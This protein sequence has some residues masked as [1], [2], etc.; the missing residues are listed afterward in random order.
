MNYKLTILAALCCLLL[1]PARLKGQSASESRTLEKSFAVK[2][3][4]SLEVTNKYGKVH[5]SHTS[6]DSVNITIEMNATASN[7]QKLRKL[8]DGV[9][10]ELNATNYFIIAETKFLKG[11][12]NLFES[13]RSITNNL[14]SSESRLEINYYIEVP[15]NIDVKVD[16]RYGDVYIE[17]LACDLNIKMNNGNLKA[18]ELSGNNFFDLNFFDATINSVVKSR[19]KLSYGEIKIVE[20]ADLNITSSSSKIQIDKSDILRV[21]SKRDKYFIEEIAE[22]EGESYFTEYSIENLN[23]SADITT[24]YGSMKVLSLKPGFDLFSLDSDYTSIDLTTTEGSSFNIDIKSINCPV[25]LPSSWKIEEKVISEERKEYLY[26]GSSGDN[27]SLSQMKINS[28]RGKL[29]ISQK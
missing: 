19:F 12:A 6:A 28:I 21:N 4:M 5:L 27:R 15:D 13:I 25:Y 20:A 29:V 3:E 23:H 14:I 17:S 16:N 22:L 1:V 26:F 10:F 24:K 8:I 7:Q 9:E 11:P 2:G 18:E